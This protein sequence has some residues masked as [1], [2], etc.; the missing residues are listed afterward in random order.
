MAEVLTECGKRAN[1]TSIENGLHRWSENIRQENIR[2]MHAL[3]DEIVA[4]RK[5]NPQPDNKDL[6]NTMLST[7]DPDTGD[8]LSDENIRNNMVTLLVMVTSNFV[9]L[10]TNSDRWRAMRQRAQLWDSPAIT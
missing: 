10:Y 2:K 5:R 4:E 3:A 8:M 9:L 6:L 1:R 7:P